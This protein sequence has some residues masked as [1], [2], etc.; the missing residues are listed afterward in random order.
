MTENR[1][2]SA[3][4][5]FEGP[6]RPLSLRFRIG[7]QDGSATVLD[8]SKSDLCLRLSNGQKNRLAVGVELLDS[9][10][11]W[12]SG[13]QCTLRRLTVL[14][15]KKDPKGDEEIRL[16]GA[17]PPTR[18]ALWLATVRQAQR[19]AEPIAPPA[20]MERHRVPKIPARGIYTEDARLERLDF[21]R[22]HSG[23]ALRSLQETTLEAHQLTGN[24]E[25]F[26]AGVE[27]PVG[28][29]GP[30]LVHG[31][32]AK[33]HIFA[34]FATTEGALVASASRG[35]T[36]ITRCGGVKTRVISQRMM[37]VPLFGLRDLDGVY[38][39]THWLRDHFGEL[40]REVRKVS[41]H[42]QLVAVNPQILGKLVHVS[43][44]FETGDAAGQNMTTACTWHACQ[45]I[46]EQV[47]YLP[48]IDIETFWIEAN[49]SGDKKV[50]FHSFIFGRGIRVTAEC[51]LADE[52]LEE[53]LKVSAEKLLVGHH[54]AMS[55]SSQIGMVGHNM[56]IANAV[57][58]IFTATGQDIASVHESALG[59]FDI[60]P[61]QGGVEAS[62]TLPSLIVGTVGGGTQLAR[63]R[64][65]LEMMGCS[66]PGPGSGSVSFP[67][68][69]TTAPMA[70]RS[71]KTWW[72]RSS[73]TTPRC[74]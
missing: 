59:F 61:A 58:A 35:A 40:R 54:C 71:T 14:D 53:V 8:L 10:L 31:Q 33:G 7:T 29:A 4:V 46:M 6:G 13:R 17:D 45:W 55:G 19:E 18:A 74:C 20:R 26:M 50:N 23:A 27:I 41:S 47:G 5:R 64:D 38:L 52:V 57:A 36:A 11:A 70:R 1:R 48:D 72:S 43:F 68:A 32:H 39:F 12:D 62:M 63:Q 44:V 42:A 49:M 67:I 34:P 21:I 15:V 25:G 73:R 56:N 30:L 2:G 22:R 51:F 60:Q 28:L 24:I 65:L 3:R 16:Q 37:R 66:G 9:T 69:C